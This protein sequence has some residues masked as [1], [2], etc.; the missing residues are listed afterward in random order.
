M[1]SSDKQLRKVEAVASYLSSLGLRHPS[2]R[3]MGTMAAL[4]SQVDDQT[5]A[6]EDVSRQ[7]ATA[8]RSGLEGL[9]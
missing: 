5:V 2:E 8:I 6:V 3:T 4:I 1:R 9:K 7:V